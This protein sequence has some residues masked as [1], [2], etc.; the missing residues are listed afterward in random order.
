MSV[1]N[2]YAKIAFAPAIATKKAE[3]KAKARKRKKR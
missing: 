2:F 3:Q 1:V